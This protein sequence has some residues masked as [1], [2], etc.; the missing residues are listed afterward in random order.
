MSSMVTRLTRVSR[1]VWPK[2]PVFYLDLCVLILDSPLPSLLLF[3]RRCFLFFSRSK[4]WGC[5]DYT[6]RFCSSDVVPFFGLSTVVGG[7]IRPLFARRAIYI[8]W[9]SHRLSG[10]RFCQLRIRSIQQS[11]FPVTGPDGSWTRRMFPVFVSSLLALPPL[12][13]IEAD[14][15]NFAL[16]GR[17]RASFFKP[18]AYPLGEFTRTDY[19]GI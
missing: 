16:E 10:P 17:V 18:N 2:C 6:R 8:A 7:V 13:S 5:T 11:S 14:I 9:N 4:N 12:L 3:G 1:C 15:G 19:V